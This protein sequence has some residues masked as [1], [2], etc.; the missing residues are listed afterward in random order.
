VVVEAHEPGIV[1]QCQAQYD[2]SPMEPNQIGFKVGDKIAI[3]SKARGNRGWW[4]GKIGGKVCIK[5]IFVSVT[6]NFTCI[7][8][9]SNDIELIYMHL[10]THL[11]SV[12]AT[13]L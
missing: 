13:L 12:Q 11:K 10:E 4:K 2:Y 8:F 9:S 6:L 7:F 1:G 3:I 5:K